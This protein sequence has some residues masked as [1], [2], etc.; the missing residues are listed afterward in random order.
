MKNVPANA[1]P[2]LLAKIGRSEKEN[3]VNVQKPNDLKYHFITRYVHLSTDTTTC[4][5][6][7]SRYRRGKILIRYGKRYRVI[8][9]QPQFL[10]KRRWRP[11]R[12]YRGTSRVKVGRKYRPIRFIRRRLVYRI[13]KKWRRI[14][15]RRRR[16][17][18]KRRRQRKRK[19]RR[20]RRKIRRIRRN[21]RR[22]RR[23]NRRIRRFRRRN[24][25]LKIYYRKKT[26]II[27]RWKGRLTVRL[28]GRRR[29]IR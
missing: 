6:A 5:F 7:Y 10:I 14:S 17:G 27:Y 13:G 15:Y 29:K 19:Y 16:K 4:L 23:R 28:G 3:P 18:R 1:Q 20:Y 8:R 12:R 25:T 26:R 21:Q 2:S 11:S 9:R 22:N 24:S